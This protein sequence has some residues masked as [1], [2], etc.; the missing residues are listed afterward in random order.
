M[1]EEN[2]KKL[3]AATL[4]EVERQ[5]DLSETNA[6]FNETLSQLSKDIHEHQ[7]VRVTDWV[8]N[9]PIS[10]SAT[11]QR[12]PAAPVVESNQ[13]PAVGLQ[14]LPIAVSASNENATGSSHLF[15]T[16][17]NNVSPKRDIP[18]HRFI[19]AYNN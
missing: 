1:Q 2:R 7:S 10:I 9:S 17:Q 4:I 12:A 14:P 18:H 6:G 15:A 16:V 3:A 8:N 19:F 13:E 5:D 11:K